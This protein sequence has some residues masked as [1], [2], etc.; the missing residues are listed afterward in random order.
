MPLFSPLCIN[1]ELRGDSSCAV[2]TL[3]DMHCTEQLEFPFA[4][5]FYTIVD[6]ALA[7]TMDRKMGGWD[8]PETSIS[9]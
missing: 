5:S 3:P 1:I 6:R 4:D 9:T 7:T 8:K 2:G